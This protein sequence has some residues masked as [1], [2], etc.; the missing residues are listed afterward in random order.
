MTSHIDSRTMTHPLHL[1]QGRHLPDLQL[2][3]IQNTK[4]L[5]IG[6]GTLGCNVARALLSWGANDI[7][8]VDNGV[9][10]PTNPLRQSLYEYSDIG[11]KKVEAASDRLRAMNPF[12]TIEG[13]Y[14]SV[15]MPGHP[16]FSTELESVEK[17]I[18]QL[19]HYIQTRDIIFL[20][21][22]TRESRWLPCL[23]GKVFH[24]TIITIGLGVD[25]FLV[26][27]SKPG[28]TCFFCN[29]PNAPTQTKGT[30]DERCT[31]TR[32]GLSMMASALAVEMIIDLLFR[33]SG[34][35]SLLASACSGKS[36]L[37]FRIYVP[38]MNIL[39][40]GEEIA[41]T[42]C[43]CCSQ[44]VRDT[45]LSQGLFFLLSLCNDVDGEILTRLVQEDDPLPESISFGE[46]YDEDESSDLLHGRPKDGSH[47][48]ESQSDQG[49]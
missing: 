39:R 47:F 49:D 27:V 19:I 32:P 7:T 8:L 44:P 31:I 11:K 6:A 41:Y 5:L 9:V 20:L 26:N 24:K 35:S 4:F 30:P 12:A 1:L 14:L 29:S 18:L 15:P 22:D 33:K 46:L 42:A 37:T 45:F 48:R 17:D 21:T 38:Q 13:R 10:S 3:K 40:S 16:I 2:D 23:L 25:S 43:T 36:S 28:S 34:K